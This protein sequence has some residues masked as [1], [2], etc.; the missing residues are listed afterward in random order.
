MSSLSKTRRN[1]AIE[2]WRF[3]VS[4]FITGY[5]ISF[6]FPMLM[7]DDVV[8][9][10]WM[11][12]GETLFIFTLTSGYFLMAHFKSR[13]R[14]P[15]FALA[16]S[17]GRA[18]VYLKGRLVR[19]LPVLMLGVFLGLVS[20]AVYYGSDIVTVLNSFVNG[21]WEYFGTYALGFEA[22]YGQA[23]GALWFI[24]ALFVC[25]Y[26][27]YYALCKNEDVTVGV[28]VPV[29]F[30]VLE[31]WWCKTG[32]RA[33]Q[34]AWTTFGQIWYANNM[35]V[36]GS[37]DTVASFGL[38]NGLVF[39]LV[40]MCGG[41][42]IWKAIDALKDKA[43]SKGAV[44]ALTCLN[45]AVSVVLFTNMLNP[46]WY[47]G[48]TLNRMTVHLLCI[49]LIFLTLLNRDKL[50]ALLNNVHCAKAFSYLG[51]LSLYIYMVHQPIIYFAVT[52]MG[53]GKGLSFNEL[54]LPVAVISIL[55]SML[56]KAVM[57]RVTGAKKA[58]A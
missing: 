49:C 43:F 35:A 48:F 47:S 39:V 30:F 54:F 50:T 31:G 8:A 29:I 57:D 55:L 38:N 56:I 18:W 17:T 33:S 58:K 42:M 25:S 4:V 53:R 14:D 32:I 6:I 11:A 21:L 28:I 40:G 3:V 24:S 20:N 37:G 34:Q 19:L 9:S 45:V 7:P 13:Q 22:A 1:T 46:G 41:I 5:H 10:T 2:I 27:L 15:E 44:A 26:I 16:S 12:N 52:I 23:N 36:N 51:S